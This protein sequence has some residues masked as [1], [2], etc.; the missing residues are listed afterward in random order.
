MC[1]NGNV[2]IFAPSFDFSFYHHF[3]TMTTCK[4]YCL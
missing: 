4:F 3:V 2:K 1:K